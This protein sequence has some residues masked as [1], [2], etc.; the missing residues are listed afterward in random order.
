MTMT[1]MTTTTTK[2]M[3]MKK[4]RKTRP[5]ALEREAALGEKTLPQLRPDPFRYYRWCWR[6][7]WH[8]P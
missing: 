1:T 7:R 8:A 5:Q 3:M 6:R 4:K 2:K